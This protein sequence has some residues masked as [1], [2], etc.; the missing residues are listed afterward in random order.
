MLPY[1][2]PM[3]WATDVSLRAGKAQLGITVVRS[4]VNGSP[5][6]AKEDHQSH[7]Q[8]NKRNIDAHH[9][10]EIFDLTVGEPDFIER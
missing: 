3:I 6:S 8:N 4:E 1:K 2:Q 5:I 10:P 7:L 9:I